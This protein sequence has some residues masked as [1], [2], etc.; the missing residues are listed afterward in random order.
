MKKLIPENIE[1]C[2]SRY[3]EK[4]RVIHGPIR[5]GVHTHCLS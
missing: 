3:S 4:A 1:V 5:R 2:G